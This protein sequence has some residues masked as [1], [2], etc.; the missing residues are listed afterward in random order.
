MSDPDLSQTSAPAAV[1]VVPE[2][3]L[4]AAAVRGDRDAVSALWESN[5]RWVAAVVLAHKPAWA[6]LDDLLQEVAATLLRKVGQVRDPGAFAP[7]L[8]MVAM[9]AARAASRDLSQRRRISPPASHAARSHAGPAGHTDAID[10]FEGLASTPSTAEIAAGRER[11][12][13]GRHLLELAADLPDAYREPLLLRCVHGMSYA[14]I[15]QV[16]ELPET[17]I[18]TRIARGRR[19]LREAARATPAALAQGDAAVLTEPRP[20]RISTGG[21]SR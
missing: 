3:A 2:D 16:L 8:R 18:E 20:L 1:G 11:L 9:N 7:W 21:A 5:R 10:G 17:T 6:D 4:F 15:G 13:H 12:E 14:Q 19:M